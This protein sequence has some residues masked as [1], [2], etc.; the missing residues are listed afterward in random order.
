MWFYYSLLSGLL[1]SGQSLLT[2]KVLKGAKK[3]SWAFSFYFSLVGALV[4]LPFFLN[5]PKT[6]SSIFAWSLILVVGILIVIQNYLNFRSSNFISASLNGAISKFRLVWIFV[7]G[8]FILK[9]SASITKIIGTVLTL[10]AG[11]MIIKGLKTKTN[12]KGILLAFSATG[13]YAVVII[14]YKFL[15]RGFNSQSL[16]FFIFFIPT[17]INIFFMP[18]AV[19]RVVALVK[20]DGASVLLAC[21]LGA[22]ANLAMNYALSIG[23][24]SRVNVTIESFLIATLVGESLILKEKDSI[25]LKIIVVAMSII[26]AVLLRI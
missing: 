21:G 3:D 14:L 1:Y 4:S 10:I 8:L 16:T 11:L 18:N 7:L 6:G 19:K 24:V 9:E 13:F 23:E 17:V 25:L 12:A 2:R 20:D 15:F 22:F 26:G 5:N